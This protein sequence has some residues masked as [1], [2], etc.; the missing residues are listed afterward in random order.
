MELEF[1]E[2]FRYFFLPADRRGEGSRAKNYAGLQMDER[3]QRLEIKGMEAVRSDWTPLARRLQ[4]DLLSM[5]FQRKPPEEMLEYIRALIRS[6]QA[7]ELDDELVYRKRIRKP[8]DAYTRTT[9]PHIKAA[10]LLPRA[11]RVVRYV[12]TE[13]GP[14][15]LGFVKAA[16]DYEHYRIKQILPIVEGLAPFAGFHADEAC[17]APSAL[18][19]KDEFHDEDFQLRSP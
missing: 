19:F 9:P 7:G 3:S 8:L 1:E 17:S 5:L 6:M 13:Q 11:V 15:P 16:V 4:R 12:L 14:Q 18:Y 2:Y 10:R